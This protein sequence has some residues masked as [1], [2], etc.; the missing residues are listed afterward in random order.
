MGGMTGSSRGL[1]LRKKAKI[2][3]KA[4]IAAAAV[5][6][7]GLWLDR[8]AASVRGITDFVLALL[9]IG[10]AMY[11]F[12][13]S[14]ELKEASGEISGTVKAV[15][16][17]SGEISGTVKA[18]AKVSAEVREMMPTRF[19]GAFPSNIEE[20]ERLVRRASC[21]LKIMAD[22]VGYGSYSRADKFHKYLVDLENLRQGRQP[23]VDIYLLVFDQHSREIVLRDQFREETWGKDIKGTDAFNRLF[24]LH[25]GRYVKAPDKYDDF[26]QILGNNHDH[27]E[28][29]LA[30]VGVIIKKRPS[31]FPFFTWLR[32]DCEAMFSFFSRRPSTVGKIREIT[33]STKDG[34]LVE[35]FDCIFDEVWN[36]KPSDFIGPAANETTG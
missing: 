26:I 15:A 35:T 27:Y 9:A 11:Q 8:Y 28:R 18:V 2:W 24:Q 22:V 1:T 19:V 34:K 14:A 23:S 32:D 10:F 25:S 13:D 20:I 31:P 16:K 30:D 5:A 29:L 3:L 6:L 17:A 36:S 12:T 33:F 7:L 4:I 21:K